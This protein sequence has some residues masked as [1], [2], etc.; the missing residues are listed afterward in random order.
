L[1]A[2]CART[3]V[4]LPKPLQ[5]QLEPQIF[6]VKIVGT[7]ALF[8]GSLLVHISTLLLLV[9]LIDQRAQH[10]LQRLAVIGQS[11]KIGFAVHLSSGRKSSLA[12]YLTH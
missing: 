8:F 6:D 4:P 9:A 11:N 5:L 10:C 3:V 2:I 7:P 1:Q 12:S